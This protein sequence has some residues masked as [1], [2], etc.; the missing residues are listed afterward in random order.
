[1]PDQGQKTEKPSKRR[2]NK[3]RKEGQFAVSRE[4]V[5]AIQFVGFVWMLAIWSGWFLYRSR[6]FMRLVFLHA[7]TLQVDRTSLRIY[8]QA[9]TTMLLPLLA[10]GSVL[11]LITVLAQLGTTQFGVSPQKLL[12]D[13]N[14]FNMVQKMRD[15]PQQGMSALTQTLL[16]LPVFGYAVY[17]IAADELAS[18][19][20]S[21][22]S[23]FTTGGRTGRRL[24]PCSPVEGQRSPAV[25]RSCGHAAE[26]EQ[27]SQ[28]SAHEQA[29]DPG[30]DER[31]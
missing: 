23:S 21:P 26:A 12:P 11:M 13:F 18:V 1:M 28:D 20:V 8:K 4:F 25:D 19:S 22:R 30:R 10:A 6:D 27:T 3:S 31:D 24:L 14:R 16:L 5:A 29:G 15:I 9:L 17:R 7:F 2:V